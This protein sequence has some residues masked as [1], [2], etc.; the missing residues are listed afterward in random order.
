MVAARWRAQTVATP[1]IDDIVIG[2]VLRGHALACVIRVVGSCPARVMSA[3]VI[4]VP[5]VLTPVGLT[6]IVV[7]A[8]VLLAVLTLPIAVALVVIAIALG[9]S[10]LSRDQ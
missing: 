3:I 7:I 8:L 1:I 10:V 2:A 9:K 4:V 6:C 5:W